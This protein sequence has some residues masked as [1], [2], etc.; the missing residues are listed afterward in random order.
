[1]IAIET[2]GAFVP[3]ETRWRSPDRR[4]LGLKILECRITP[5]S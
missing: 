4:R 5:A 2:D 1:V 3:A